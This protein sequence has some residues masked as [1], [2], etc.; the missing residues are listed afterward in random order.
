MAWKL[1][2]SLHTLRDQVNNNYPKRS[3]KSDGTIGDSAHSKRAS[4]HNPNSRGD[5]TALDLTHDPAGGFDAHKF[6][7][8]LRA[9]RDPRIKYIISNRRIFS[10]TGNG[11]WEWRKYTGSNP[12]SAHIHISASADH[13]RYNS[14]EPW[15]M[16]GKVVTVGH[17]F[18]D[19]PQSADDLPPQDDDNGIDDE[20]MH[21]RPEVSD[22]DDDGHSPDAA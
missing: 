16:P 6:A 12:H 13:A 8:H 7:E 15:K 19:L 10:S 1:A 3:K 2:K 17:G 22:G 18:A 21:D 20:E 9:A 5:V 14:P 11:A 4:D